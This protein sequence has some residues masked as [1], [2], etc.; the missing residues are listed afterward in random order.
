MAILLKT[1]GMKAAAG[2]EIESQ[3]V[4]D[5]EGNVRR[6]LPSK[7]F[8]TNLQH[9]SDV[10]WLAFL[11]AQYG[12]SSIRATAQGVLIIEGVVK[13]AAGNGWS[14]E[15]AGSLRA[16]TSHT[17]KI[18]KRLLSPARAAIK[19]AEELQKSMSLPQLTP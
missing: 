9:C 16:H 1:A 10:G 5:E 8:Y 2:L 3:E 19:N 4:K 18:S 15:G 13:A 14:R 11:D 6:T 12:M 17:Y 7:F